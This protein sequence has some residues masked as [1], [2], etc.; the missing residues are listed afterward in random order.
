MARKVTQKRLGQGS[1]QFMV[2]L[3]E[4]MRDEIA[5]QAQQNGRSMNAEIIARLDFSFRELLSP[6]GLVAM[7]KRLQAG[8]EGLEQLFFDV[9][10]GRPEIAAKPSSANWRWRGHLMLSL[11]TCQVALYPATSDTPAFL[12]DTSA[13]AI[14]GFVPRSEIN[15]LYVRHG[16]YL[17]PDP[18]SRIGHDAFALI[19][20]SI[21]AADKAALARV[22]LDNGSTAIMA[23]EARDAGMLGMLLRKPSEIRDPAPFFRDVQDVHVTKDMLELSKHIVEMKSG[24][25]DAHELEEVLAKEMPAVP[26][27]PT[28]VI[29]MADHLRKSVA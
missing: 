25:F 9:R 15:P 16:C 26:A 28:N 5:K 21:R 23:F 1:D 24:H 12:S 7:T 2:R 19:R 4:G 18:D 3:P 11:V 8:V 17:L 13:I 20:E 22:G 14:D 10:D 6:E 27:E 29:N